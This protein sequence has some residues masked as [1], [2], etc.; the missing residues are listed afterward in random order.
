M[1]EL[2]TFE[3]ITGVKF[4][5]EFLKSRKSFNVDLR[6]LFVNLIIKNNSNVE[7]NR[8]SKIINKDRAT[9]R[10]SNKRFIRLYDV[11]K[12]YRKMADWITYSFKEMT[13]HVL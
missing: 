10:H 1:T 6:C 4:T 9:V 8:I 7:L 11:D 13:K 5:P 12:S 3:K 2:E